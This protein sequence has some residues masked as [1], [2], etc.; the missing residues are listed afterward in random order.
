MLP[1]I[2]PV[3]TGPDRCLGRTQDALTSNPAELTLPDDGDDGV[4][5]MSADGGDVSD[6]VITTW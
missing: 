5:G 3:P 2:S 1:Y 4:L 6:D